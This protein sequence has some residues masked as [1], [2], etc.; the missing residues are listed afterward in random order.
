MTAGIL[1]LFA[2]DKGGLVF[3]ALVVI[4][5]VAV[6]TAAT[7]LLSLPLDLEPAVLFRWL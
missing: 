5:L 7:C 4:T 2:A 6:C 3:I 1:R